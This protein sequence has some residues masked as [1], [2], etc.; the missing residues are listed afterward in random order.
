MN[1]WCTEAVFKLHRFSSWSNVSRLRTHTTAGHEFNT[2]F[3]KGLLFGLFCTARV[4][5]P[6]IFTAVSSEQECHILQFNCRSLGLSKQKSRLPPLNQIYL[7]QCQQWRPRSPI[8]LNYHR[9][10]H[11]FKF[12]HL[13]LFLCKC[14]RSPS[15][16]HKH[17]HTTFHQ[18]VAVF[19]C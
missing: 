3:S 6:W 7:D 13:H 11:Y 14:L 10:V 12:K 8:S 9:Q 15:H 2:H 5:A 1:T 16:T 18:D 19:Y 4:F 17:H